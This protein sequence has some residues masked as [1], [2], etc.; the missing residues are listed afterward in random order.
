MVSW[1]ELLRD[2]FAERGDDISTMVCTLTKEELLV[3]FDD[4]SRKIGGVPFTAWGKNY[5][6]FPAQDDGREWVDSV[7]R[8]P[9]GEATR[10]IGG[11]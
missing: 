11:G 2:E 3:Q 9:N 1:L 8:H 5:V 10:H 4:R 7:P 6:Y